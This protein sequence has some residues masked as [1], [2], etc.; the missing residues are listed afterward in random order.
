VACE[1]RA[2]G[3][4]PD[5]WRSNCQQT[6]RVPLRRGSG[7][8]LDLIGRAKP[9]CSAQL[10]FSSRETIAGCG[11]RVRRS[12]AAPDFTRSTRHSRPARLEPTDVHKLTTSDVTIRETSAND[13]SRRRQRCRRCTSCRACSWKSACV[14]GSAASQVPAASSGVRP[15][16]RA[17][18]PA[19][20]DHQEAL[21]AT[22][23]PPCF[24]F[25]QRSFVRPLSTR[26]R[27]IAVSMAENTST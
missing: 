18:F 17:H 24:A 11:E 23:F 1:Q 6:Q 10:L 22:L 3:A 25:R 26:R 15:V 16:R 27:V 8:L 20:R 14:C 9:S 4:E 13:C 19:P 7:R 12:V 2:D 5:E 21:S